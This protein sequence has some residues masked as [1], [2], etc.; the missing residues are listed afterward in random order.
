[1]RPK[2]VFRIETANLDFAQ[3][4]VFNPF[5][6]TPAARRKLTTT[7][8]VCSI[9]TEGLQVCVPRG[10]SDEARTTASTQ[11]REDDFQSNFSPIREGG[12]TECFRVSDTR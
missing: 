1:M 12:C 3:R 10:H 5:G 11:R 6:K 2:E 4:T 8:E 7:D 9:L